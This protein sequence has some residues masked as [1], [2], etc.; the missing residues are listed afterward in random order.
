MS[1]EHFMRDAIAQALA[2]A[3]EGEPPFG[4]LIVTAE[5]RVLSR[6]HDTVRQHADMTRHAEVAAVRAACAVRGPDLSGCTLYTTTEP[7]P[8]CFT[9]AWLARI[10]RIVFGSTM[11]EVGVITGGLQREAAVAAAA[12]NSMTGEEITLVGG[13]LREAC[14]EPFR[15]RT[16]A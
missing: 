11:L 13:V 9:A 8:M 1:D 14:L 7:C 16:A 12:M 2:G 3:G 4:A 5:G 15:T 6:A 10:S